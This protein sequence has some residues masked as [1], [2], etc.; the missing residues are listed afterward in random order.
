VL[1]VAYA[2]AGID[3]EVV[4]RQLQGIE[5]NLRLV[6]PSLAV[7]QRRLLTAEGAS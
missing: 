6:S 5:E 3:A 7:V 1:Y 4:E 2:P